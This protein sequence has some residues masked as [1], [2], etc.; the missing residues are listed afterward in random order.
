M[1]VEEP[2]FCCMDD[3]LG[4]WPAEPGD[5]RSMRASRPVCPAPVVVWLVADGLAPG[6]EDV[7]WAAV[8]GLPGCVLP[9]V[10][11]LGFPEVPADPDALAPDA[12]VG[13]EAVEP[14]EF[15]DAALEPELVPLPDVVV[16]EE[17]AEDDVLAPPVPDE[18]GDDE[19]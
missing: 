3:P 10:R 7:P 19:V 12:P 4:C 9:D 16:L 17:G 1:R 2:V 5:C 13:E 15:G 18:P 8:E 6:E 14:P 11:V